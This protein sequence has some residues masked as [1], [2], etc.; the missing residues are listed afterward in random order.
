MF[1]LTD[2]TF[3]IRLA[4][5]AHIPDD[6]SNAD[7]QSYQVWLAAGNTPQPPDPPVQPTPA[8]QIDALERATL[9]SR[10]VRDVLLALMEEKAASLGLT[11]AQ[12]RQVNP[13]YRRVKDLDDQIA[14]LRAQL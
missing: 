8:S 3:V 10:P 9:L 7:R 6:P 1:K 5:S 4:D 2:S 12:L 14:A 13:G 11:P